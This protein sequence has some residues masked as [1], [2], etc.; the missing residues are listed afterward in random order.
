MRCAAGSQGPRGRTT[1][2]GPLPRSAD[3]PQ[4]AHRTTDGERKGGRWLP[5]RFQLF[6]CSS[7]RRAALRGIILRRGRANLLCRTAWRMPLI[8]PGGRTVHPRE[9]LLG[10]CASFA[11]HRSPGIR[12]FAPSRPARSKGRLCTWQHC[13]DWDRTGRRRCSVDHDLVR[14]L[15]Q[16]SSSPSDVPTCSGSSYQPQ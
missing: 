3:S 5:D 11:L 9:R 13:P 4:M 12:L 1:G 15:R 8:F 10:E 2:A 6:P 14:V 16:K 7:P